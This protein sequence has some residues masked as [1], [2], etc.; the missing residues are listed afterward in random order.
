MPQLRWV[1]LLPVALPLWTPLPVQWAPL[2]TP[3]ALPR[4][5]LRSTLATEVPRLRRE[6][7]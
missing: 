7:P 1:T 5:Q 4:M 6:R 2:P 3:P